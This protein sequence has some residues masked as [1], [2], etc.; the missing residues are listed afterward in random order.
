MTTQEEEA[1]NILQNVP[2]GV[3]QVRFE[4]GKE[5]IHFCNFNFAKMF[6]YN[7]PQEL[8]GIDISKL[9]KPK[10]EYQKFLWELEKH[11]HKD[12]PFVGYAFRIKK[13]DGKSFTLEINSQPQ[14][15]D[16]GEV[17]GRYCVVRDITHESH[18][19]EL[20]YVD[21]EDI[22]IVLHNFSHALLSIYSNINSTVE[23]FK[24]D[25]FVDYT[26]N[27]YEK[28]IN[29]LAKP[30]TDL[31]SLLRSYLKSHN[32][33]VS[34]EVLKEV[35]RYTVMLE[36][37]DSEI[38]KRVQT[39]V[40]KEIIMELLGLFETIIIAGELNKI[41]DKIIYIAKD[42]VRVCNLV[43][44]HR[45]RNIILDM[46]H[47]LRTL[48]EYITSMERDHMTKATISVKS[49]ITR[50]VLNMLTYAKNNNVLI[51]TENKCPNIEIFAN[52]DE[53]TRAVGNLIHNAIKY[54]YKR[55][56]GEV[57]WIKISLNKKVN[58]VHCEVENYGVPITH[59]EIERGLI[60]RL[61]FR[62]IY[63]DKKGSLGIG[64]GL[65][66]T[67]SIAEKYGGN[68]V[69]KSVPAKK[70]LEDNDYTQPFVT[71]VTLIIPVAEYYE[72]KYK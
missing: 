28:A 3:Y 44:L 36:N 50:A 1:R 31:K 55:P 60:F 39:A 53:I 7:N 62:G 32:N 5:I 38:P 35:D 23:Y 69:V 22:G 13:R 2:V 40:L 66:N 9:Y 10:E 57:A 51:R 29:I 59:E 46:D 43:S 30:V 26:E 67:L 70:Q 58:Y 33:G 17:I 42:I 12:L 56:K 6:G 34:D 24:P 14:T 48:R 4:K 19:R 47:Q 41:Q 49:M 18:L 25:P 27:I 72:E 8:I 16:N 71:T 65:T 11:K 61:G 45:V 63:S 37:F 52:E 21:N 54:S 15:N 20:V 64:I 68:V